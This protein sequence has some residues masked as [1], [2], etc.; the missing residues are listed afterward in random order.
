MYAVISGLSSNSE[1]LH[2]KLLIN[3]LLN[4]F[5]SPIFSFKRFVLELTLSKIFISI[6]FSLETSRAIIGD[7]TIMKKK[8][9]IL[10]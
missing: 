9:I 1:F 4:F 3:K 5:S 10:I 2:F 6:N 8:K 7:D